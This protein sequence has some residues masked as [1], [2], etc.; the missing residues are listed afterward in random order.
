VCR[1]GRAVS[2]WQDL[3][4]S[5][6][7]TGCCWFGISDRRLR[8]TS[9]GR[10][11]LL[12]DPKRSVVDGRGHSCRFPLPRVDPGPP[13]DTARTT[14]QMDRRPSVASPRSGMLVSLGCGSMSRASHTPTLSNQ[15][16]NRSQT[17]R[18]TPKTHT[19]PGFLRATDKPK[20]TRQATAR[21]RCWRAT[22][23]IIGGLLPG[24][25]RSCCEGANPRCDHGNTRSATH[26]PTTR[27]LPR[28]THRNALRLAIPRRGPTGIP[29]G[30]AYSLP[31]GRR[32]T[33]D[34]RPHQPA[35][36]LTLR[37]SPVRR[38]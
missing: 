16:Q 25:L 28:G 4:G 38:Q 21:F 12:L 18:R 19:R 3:A 5:W 2:R 29:S 33:L 23:R 9:G 7:S 1:R 36:W 8:P 13:D 15:S 32:R 14:P 6:R 31:V 26:S 34:Q 20:R 22:D 35:H 27:R 10:C 11:G 37:D 17:R 30:K 24:F